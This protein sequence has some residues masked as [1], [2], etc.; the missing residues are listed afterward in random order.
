MTEI[1]SVPQKFGSMCM[2]V[3]ASRGTWAY[4]I[5]QIHTQLVLL[6]SFWGLH[7]DVQLSLLYGYVDAVRSEILGQHSHFHNILSLEEL[8]AVFAFL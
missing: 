4:R 1:D 3:H 8:V 6:L 2:V 5:V 7:N